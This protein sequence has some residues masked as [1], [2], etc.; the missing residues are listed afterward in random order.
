MVEWDFA[1]SVT[2]MRLMTELGVEH[3]L[4][5]HACL[6]ETDVKEQ[7]LADPAMLVSA[8]QEMR[9]IRNVLNHLGTVA[10]LGLQAG[11]RYHF[12]AFG[13]LGFAMVS[14][15]NARSALDVTLRYFQLT[16][17]F[18]RLHVEDHGDQTHITLDASSLPEDVR[19]FIVERDA[20]ALVTIQRDLFASR[21][22][23]Q[24]I[25]FTRR[26]PDDPQAYAS[27]FGVAPVF[28]ASSNVAVM[29]SSVLMEP[30]SQGNALA[31]KAAQAQ[32]SALLERHRSGAGLA[33]KVKSLLTREGA[34]MPGM[35]EV[36]DALCMTPRTLRRRLLEEGATFLRLREQV[37]RATAEDL[38]SGASLS[39][40]RIADRLGYA[41]PTCF[42]NAFR[43][44]T[45]QTPLVY[46]KAVHR[47]LAAPERG[48]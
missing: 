31:F 3:G 26:A 25:R 6:A 7:D 23:L 42:I 10:G 2:S 27:F 5:A 43:R 9:L 37:R 38:L 19:A 1:R 33:A 20:A 28:G 13:A 47:A 36:A 21:P 18:T 15:P 41:E 40:E 48:D 45:G 30:L 24:G 29:A 16:F 34:G 39:V 8:A 44:W 4:P 17:A 22:V 11:Q 12:T 35:E 14:S 46:R 32:C